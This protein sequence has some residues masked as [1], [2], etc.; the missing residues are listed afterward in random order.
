MQ[1]RR[2][3]DDNE[4]RDDCREQAA[5]DHIGAG[6]LVL[7]DR[8][9]LFDDRR[10]QVKLHPR[11][12]G[13]ADQTD[14]QREIAVIPEA[15]AVRPGHRRQRRCPPVRLCQHTRHHVRH[16]EQR[17]R[18]E[19]FFDAV[20]SAMHHQ[21]PHEQRRQRH[22]Y[23][24]RHLEQLERAGDAGEFRD[25]I[26]EVRHDQ[27]QHQEEGDAKAEFLADQIAQAFAG[28]RPHPRRHLLDHH[29][30]D[31]RRDHHPQQRVAELCPGDGVGSD[32][33][34]VVVDA[35]GDETGTDH[36]QRK[37]E[38]TAPALAKEVFHGARLSGGAAA[39]RSRRRR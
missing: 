15:D 19:D 24:L 23:V 28:H 25:D 7:P 2:A 34:G 16:V 35:G 9:A 8:D 12:D 36:R 6:R 20:V 5:D 31:G 21:R 39:W 37:C 4:P 3:G 11:R 32:A 27:R 30:R 10:L 1:R 33:A 14:H 26:A 18:Q 17:R 29:Q 38:T 22:H 13:G